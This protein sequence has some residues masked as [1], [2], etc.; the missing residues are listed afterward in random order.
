MTN[1]KLHMRF[2]LT[3]GSMTL[4]WMTLNSISMNQRISRDLSD[5]GHN[6]S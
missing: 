4:E 6:N 1:R 2:Q 5:F 3:P